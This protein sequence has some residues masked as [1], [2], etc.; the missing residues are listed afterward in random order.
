MNKTSCFAGIVRLFGFRYEHFE[1][2]GVHLGADRRSRGFHPD[3]DI[4]HCKMAD[5]YGF[6]AARRYAA[7]QTVDRGQAVSFAG[8]IEC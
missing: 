5:S 4:I 7:G 3:N 6:G 1:Y 8:Q 2:P